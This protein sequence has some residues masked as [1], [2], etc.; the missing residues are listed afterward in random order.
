MKIRR[1][2]ELDLARFTALA[3]SPA[4]DRALQT[5]NEGGGYWSYDP[6]RKST[7]DIVGATTP[8]LGALPRLPWKQ[9]ELQI[10]RACKNSE[11]Q[12]L[13][14]IE[15]G[16]VLYEYS[17]IRNWKAAKYQ[18]GLM[19]IGVDISVRYWNDLILADEDGAFIPFF[20]HRRENG[21]TN[22]DILRVIYSMQ[23]IWVRE[24]RPDLA[25]FRLAVIKFSNDCPRRISLLFHNGDALLSFDELNERVRLVYEAW[26]RVL[27]SKSSKKKKTGTDDM[28][29]LFETS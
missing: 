22:S 13:A 5:Y 10:E 12:R 7:S 26:D 24:R 8:L 21:V 14:N 18:L 17:K 6:V 29:D 16:K 27:R 20:D 9:L 3:R 2:S 23:H 25:S 28:D 19:P 15:A 11:E 4:L 1:F